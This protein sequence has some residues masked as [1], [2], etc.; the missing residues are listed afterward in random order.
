MMTV[1]IL[2]LCCSLLSPVRFIIPKCA[3]PPKKN[4]GSASVTHFVK[5]CYILL[6]TCSYTRGYIQNDGNLE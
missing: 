4:F 6:A 2:I 1:V 5:N 3:P